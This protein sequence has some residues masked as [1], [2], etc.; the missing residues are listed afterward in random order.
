M[1]PLKWHGMTW[2]PLKHPD[3]ARAA[4]HAIQRA[5][6]PPRGGKARGLYGARWAESRALANDRP[7]RSNLALLPAPGHA[8][9]LVGDRLGGR[10]SL[11]EKEWVN[12]MRRHRLRQ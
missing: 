8:L 7:S 4:A 2:K 10:Q 9:P 5:M 1:G 11:L 6:I 3:T 12:E